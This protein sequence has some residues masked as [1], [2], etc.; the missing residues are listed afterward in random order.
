MLELGVG[1]GDRIRHFAE[2]TSRTLWGFDWFMGLPEDW[3]QHDRIG[4]FST[5]GEVPRLPDN[6]R[7]I[8]GL[9]QLTLPQFL[10]RHKEPVAFVHF[11]L[12]LYSATSFAL[13]MLKDR[14]A[15][16]AIVMF[17]EMV[18]RSRNYA[19]EGKAFC[20]FLAATNHA[21]EFLGQMHGESMIFKLLTS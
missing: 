15:H 8:A 11:D 9:I 1:G 2:R 19:H 20:E 18:G 4:T 17:D 12:D 13:M 21:A 5:F 3:D 16:G 6:C 14:F 7:V 10:L